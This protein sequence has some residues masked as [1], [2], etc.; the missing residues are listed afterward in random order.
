M[1]EI[2]SRLDR[3]LSDADAPEVAKCIAV[4][5]AQF[6]ARETDDQ[7]TAA[8]AEGYLLALDGVPLFALREAVRLVLSGKAE[9]V[10]TRWMPTSAQIR[11]LAD[12][13]ALPAK[14]HRV[15]LRRLLEAEVER[16]APAGPRA[17][18]PE[19]QAFLGAMQPRRRVP[20]NPRVDHS[21]KEF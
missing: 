3:H 5:Q 17:L 16:A 11:E 7:S 19:V 12:R 8:R 15:Q 21:N 13:L 6:P 2:C 9:G 14:A 20:G 1:T 4:L 18:P 10:N